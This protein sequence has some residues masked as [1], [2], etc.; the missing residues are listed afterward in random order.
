MASAAAVS[1]NED[2][3]PP[4]NTL[5]DDDGIP[6]T[7]TSGIYAKDDV[8]PDANG[9]VDEDDEDDEDLPANPLRGRKTRPAVNGDADEENQRDPLDLFGDDDDEGAA[10]TT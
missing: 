5:G 9:E 6:G 10:K 2:K 1:A 8:L 4:R 7:V 3:S